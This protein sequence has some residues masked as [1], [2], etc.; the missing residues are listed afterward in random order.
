MSAFV[1]NSIMRRSLV[2]GVVAAAAC[3]GSFTS[4]AM[5]SGGNSHHSRASHNHGRRD[6]DR[7]HERRERERRE[8][9][10]RRE[11]HRRHEENRR[12]DCRTSG[13]RIDIGLPGVII[14]GR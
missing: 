6:H 8:E 11:E 14:I 7:A 1:T 2:L 9:A 13:I 4:T 5:A 10:R 12:R 3:I